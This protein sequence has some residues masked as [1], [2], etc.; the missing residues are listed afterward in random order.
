MKIGIQARELSGYGGT[1]VYVTSILKELQ[2]ISDHQIYLFNSNGSYDGSSHN[3]FEHVS[4]LTRSPVISDHVLTRKWICKYDID[5]YWQPKNT[6]PF[7]GISGTQSV[8][9]IH[10]LGHFISK[11]YYPF[12]SR[13]YQ[14]KAI[15]NSCKN[16]DSIIAISQGTKQDILRYTSA[17]EEEIEV[18]YHGVSGEIK[19]VGERNIDQLQVKINSSSKLIYGGNLGLRKNTLRLVEAFSN[20]S[21][22][23]YTLVFTGTPPND[24]IQTHLEQTDRVRSLGYVDSEIVSAL[25][26][27]ADVFVYP[28][29]YEGFGLPILEAM[30]CGTPVITTNTSS[31]PEVAGDAAILIDPHSVPEIESAIERVLND[32][33]LRSDLIRRGEQRAQKFSWKKTAMETIATLVND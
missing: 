6:L 17:T 4:S 8:V 9:T 5:V 31:I 1:H 3:N 33:Q 11:D 2:K 32:T 10:D 12:I 21:F 26:V 19:T 16:A 14:K 25:Y 7:G 18:I 29:L 27:A 20:G 28:S 24:T 15:Q 23:D 13:F 22:E 30:M